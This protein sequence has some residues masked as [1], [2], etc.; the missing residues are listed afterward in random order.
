MSK[1][2]PLTSAWSALPAPTV[3]PEP[4]VR[5]SGSRYGFFRQVDFLQLLALVFLLGTGLLFIKSIGEQIGTA[6]AAGFFTK[7]L[8]WLATGCGIWLLGSLLNTRKTEFK[9]FIVILYVLA[10]LLLFLVPFFGVKVYG[11]TRWLSLGGL[12]L[13]PS[14]LAK[15]VA[16]MMLALLFSLEGL[17][18]RSW[19]GMGLAALVTVIPFILILREPDLGSAVILIPVFGAILFVS[20]IPWRRLLVLFLVLG[21]LSALLITNEVARF[22]PLLRDYQLDRIKTF[23]NPDSDRLYRGYNA[24]QARLAVGSGG[25]TGKGIGEGT[26]NQL[27]FLPQTVSNNDFIFSV[28]AEETGFIGGTLLLFGY[29]LLLYS[30]FRTAWL[31][32]DLWGRGFAVGIGTML[33]CQMFINMGMSLGVTPVTGLPLSLVSYGGSAIVCLMGPLGILQSIYRRAVGEKAD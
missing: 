23:L 2:R 11:A 29:L 33:F 28:I 16:A 13:Q 30:I 31:S 15:P 6:E 26:Q 24:Y 20:G 21:C 12:R 25:F 19:T 7:Q 17:S 22:R 14:E 10:L 18:G 9:V 1:R 8:Q 5:E 4:P 32:D 3:S 27:G